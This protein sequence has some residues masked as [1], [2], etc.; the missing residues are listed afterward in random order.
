LLDVAGRAVD[1][2]LALERLIARQ[3]ARRLLHASLDLIL[4]STDGHLI[5]PGRFL[6]PRL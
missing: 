3:H 4:L 1:F 5:S 6:A 2:T